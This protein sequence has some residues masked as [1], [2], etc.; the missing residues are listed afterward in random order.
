MNTIMYICIFLIQIEIIIE[1]KNFFTN[2]NTPF[3]RRSF[4][5]KSISILC[6]KYYLLNLKKVEIMIGFE[7]PLP[8]ADM[9]NAFNNHKK[10]ETKK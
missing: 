9:K 1:F 8:K 10:K 7:L 4:L 6:K 2:Y 3:I 5:K